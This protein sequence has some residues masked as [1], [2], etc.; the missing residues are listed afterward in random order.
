MA[1]RQAGANSMRQYDRGATQLIAASARQSKIDWLQMAP[2]Q[3]VAG[4]LDYLQTGETLCEGTVS[5]YIQC[6]RTAIGR[7]LGQ[8][9]DE[10]FTVA[11]AAARDILVNRGGVPEPA[12]GASL[13]LKDPS[14]ADLGDVFSHLRSK[15]IQ[16]ADPLDLLLAL[17]I[18]VM[19][20]IGLRPIE[21]TWTEWNGN[22]LYTRSAK[23]AG[24]PRRYIPHEHWPPVF[25]AALGLFV[26][27]V[28][29]DLDD[30]SFDAWRNRLASRL[31]RASRWTRTGRRLSL[32]FARDI[33]IATWK[34]LGITPETIAILAGHAGL[35]S[36]HFYASGR[37]GYGARHVF[38][39]SEQAQA[40]LGAASA[41]EIAQS[42]VIDQDSA[43]PARDS[44]SS[45]GPLDPAKGVTGETEA[46]V[47]TTPDFDW[48][49][50]PAPKRHEETFSKEGERLWTERKLEHDAT[51]KR[52][53][54]DI[55]RIRAQKAQ[56]A[57]TRIDGDEGSHHSNEAS[58]AGDQWRAVK[59][60]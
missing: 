13:K 19:P 56:A 36:Q 51:W 29:R 42:E 60:K 44:A 28:P 31:A 33:A 7:I 6:A 21:I 43:A 37:S 15:Y 47:H 46:L 45:S 14:S 23:R 5:H 26:R 59:P 12:R 49:D 38:L 9:E 35:R 50:M 16:D 27:L 20:R 22:Q 1:V 57:L 39:D 30:A 17:Y 10:E 25:K 32:Y 8:T 18:I 54:G 58:P 2:A 55:A 48:D 52:L 41:G 24:R 3:K 4:L 11:A 40:L 53:E 34:Q